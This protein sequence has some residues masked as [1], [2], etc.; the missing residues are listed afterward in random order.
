MPDY[1]V[2]GFI[3]NFLPAATTLDTSD[4]DDLMK[5][6]IILFQHDPTYSIYQILANA[7][8]GTENI[9]YF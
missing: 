7:E 9:I 1:E 8:H 2:L 6:K 5:F 4:P 3:T